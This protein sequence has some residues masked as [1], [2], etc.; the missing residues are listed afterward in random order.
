MLNSIIRTHFWQPP[1][2][3]PPAAAS[4]SRV[5]DLGLAEAWGQ[6]EALQYWLMAVK[7]AQDL[8]LVDLPH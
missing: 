1:S 7:A 6:A 5:R 4:S 2:P 8:P 3:L